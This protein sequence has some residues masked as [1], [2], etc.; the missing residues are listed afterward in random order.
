M[1]RDGE[2]R[3]MTCP[4]SSWYLFSILLDAVGDI[5]SIQC[6]WWWPGRRDM[7]DMQTSACSHSYDPGYLDLGYLNLGHSK[8]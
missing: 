2:L 4:A 5:L 3:N 6:R 7:S 1:P 8:S